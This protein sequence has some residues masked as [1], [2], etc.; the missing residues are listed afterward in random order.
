MKIKILFLGLFILLLGCSLKVNQINPK[1]NLFIK[2]SSKTIAIVFDTSI[3][4]NFTIPPQNGIEKIKVKKWKDS[5]TRGFKNGFS[6]F[7]KIV[8]D[9]T[10]S[11]LILLLK[12]TDIFFEPDPNEYNSDLF[13]E[14]DLVLS[15]IPK[16]KFSAVLLNKQ[17][18]PLKTIN[19]TAIAKNPITGE[20]QT[21]KGVKSAVESMYEKIAK[22]LFQGQ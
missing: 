14:N 17:R 8:D 5:L 3:K 15:I 19:E 10:K 12:G 18:K 2:K 4:N 9:P 21:S 7:Y 13:F 11:D 22:K 1:P 16:I 6:I 20:F